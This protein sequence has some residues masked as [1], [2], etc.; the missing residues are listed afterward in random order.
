[1]TYKNYGKVRILNRVATN[2]GGLVLILVRLPKT[3]LFPQRSRNTF[4]VRAGDVL[5]G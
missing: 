5:P 1:M 4:W 3:A 2:R